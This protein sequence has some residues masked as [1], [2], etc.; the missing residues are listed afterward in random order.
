MSELPQITKSLLEG[1]PQNISYNKNN[2]NIADYY[3]KEDGAVRQDISMFFGKRL[4]DIFIFAMAVGKNRGA[5]TPWTELPKG[6]K[7]MTMP[8]DALREEEIWLMTCVAISHD[9]NGIEII[10]EPHKIVEI[11][12]GYAN[13]GISLLMSWD[14]S[15]RPTEKFEEEFET[16]LENVK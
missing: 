11:C 8:T 7:S 16:L 9:K 2:N 15:I 12:E 6:S 4:L 5:Y 3:S 10:K 1:W 14:K 13:G